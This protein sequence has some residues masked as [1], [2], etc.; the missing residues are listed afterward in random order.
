MEI[1]VIGR[2][3][4]GMRG[5]AGNLE[6]GYYVSKNGIRYNSKSATEEQLYYYGDSCT[7][8]FKYNYLKIEVFLLS[9]LYMFIESFLTC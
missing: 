6:N 9:F 7:Y 2:N 5:L 8:Y 4:T 3:I 1:R